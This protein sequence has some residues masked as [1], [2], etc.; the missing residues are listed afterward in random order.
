MPTYL[1]IN[2]KCSE[3]E[4]VWSDL[5]TK[6]ELDRD[7]WECPVCNTET[8]HRTV[9]SVLPLRSTE[10]MSEG[11]FA[12]LKAITKLEKQMY[13]KPPAERGEAQSEIAARKKLK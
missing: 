7:V 9:N 13:D 8:G 3:C 12:D 2:I 6:T 4:R 10:R 11:Q 5:A 1:S